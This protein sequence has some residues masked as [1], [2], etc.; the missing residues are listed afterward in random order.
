MQECLCITN[1]LLEIKKRGICG[2]EVVV[3]D[4]EFNKSNKHQKQT[5]NLKC[6]NIPPESGKVPELRR[7]NV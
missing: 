6:C 5:N 7:Q 4:L 2:L 3:V 1:V